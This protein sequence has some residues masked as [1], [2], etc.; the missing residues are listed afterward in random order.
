MILD[1]PT[2]IDFFGAAN[3]Y[4]NSSWGSVIEL[5]SEFEEMRSVVEDSDHEEESERYWSSAKQTLISA[6]VVA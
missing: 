5:L 1:F 6:I 3:D 2:K 4:L